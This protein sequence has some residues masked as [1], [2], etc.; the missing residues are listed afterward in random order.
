[1]RSS[2]PGCCIGSALTPVDASRASR[3]APSRRQ[4]HS[5]Q[6]QSCQ[7]RKP[8]GVDLWRPRPGQTWSSSGDIL[9][10]PETGWLWRLCR[11]R[12]TSSQLPERV[13]MTATYG[14]ASSTSVQVHAPTMPR[15]DE[16][17]RLLIEVIFV[18]SVCLKCFPHISRKKLQS[19]LLL[20]DQKTK[21]I[22]KN[23]FMK[24]KVFCKT[25]KSVFHQA[26]PIS[27]SY[28]PCFWK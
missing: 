8:A 6:G 18:R 16:L 3:W 11:L 7:P 21:Y 24:K 14:S 17:H 23:W 2:Q 9:R 22:G 15:G 4:A 12:G 5:R 13:M 27:T 20:G 19:T 1:M 26:I 25:F 28:V 10:R